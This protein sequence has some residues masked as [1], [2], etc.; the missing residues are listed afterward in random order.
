MGQCTHIVCCA[1]CQR[2]GQHARRLWLKLATILGAN[3]S[4]DGVDFRLFSVILPEKII[5]VQDLFFGFVSC[6]LTRITQP[7]CNPVDA[8]VDTALHA[9]VAVLLGFAC[10]VAAD[11][12]DLQVVQW[13]NIRK[14]VLDAA[15]Q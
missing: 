7:R 10:A 2:T 15:G 13:V 3:Y 4:H 9:F 12:L 11:Q 1:P 14:A 5:G 6:V 8:D